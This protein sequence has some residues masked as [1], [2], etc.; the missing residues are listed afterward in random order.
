[1]EAF[2][3]QGSGV[4][5]CYVGILLQYMHTPCEVADRDDFDAADLLAAALERAGDTDLP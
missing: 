4:P 2:A 1:M 5:A 3:V